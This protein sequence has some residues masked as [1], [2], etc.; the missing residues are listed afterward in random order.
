MNLTTHKLS[1]TNTA[2]LTATVAQTMIQWHSTFLQPLLPAL[3]FFAGVTYD[4]LTLTRIDRLLD[5]LIILLYITLLGALIILTG[6]FQLG[7]VPSTPD[8]PGWHVLSLM[9]RARPH[10]GKVLQFLLGGLFSAYAI[11]YSQSASW[12]TTA[13]FLG[14]IVGF[15]IANEFL[16]NRYSSLKMLVGLFAIVTLSFMTFFLPVLTGWMNAWVFLTGAVITIAVVWKT[17]SLTLRGIPNLP[18][19]APLMIGLPGFTLVGVCTALYFLNWIPPIPLSLKSGGIY[20]H[21]EKQQNHYLLTYEEGPWYAVWKRSDDRVGTD[22]PVYSFSSVFAPITLHTTIYHHWE[23]RPTTESASF[24]TTDRIPI[25][26][27]GGREHGYRMY[28]MKQRLQPG[29]WRVNVETEDG[30]LIGRITFSADANY[31]PSHDL[32]T[33]TQ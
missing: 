27:T 32:T 19:R 15:L 13:I 12:S 26:I 28:T 2:S 14:I 24:I 23:W 8:V 5:N 7:L 18:V 33:I 16:S 1:S 29:E 10:F 31:S 21:I 6:R 4:T 9:H 20:H 25:S 30:R 17:V 3:F 11:L 22:A